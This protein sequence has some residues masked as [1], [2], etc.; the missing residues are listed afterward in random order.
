MRVWL[1]GVH[2]AAHDKVIII[3]AALPGAAVIT[4]SYNFTRAAQQSNAENVVVLS[5]NR[6]IAERFL[7]NFEKHRSESRPWR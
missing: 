3:D 6:A 2:A 5:G 1:D 4:G 7:A